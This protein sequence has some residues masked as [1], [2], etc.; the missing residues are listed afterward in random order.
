MDR[1]CGGLLP[2]SFFYSLFIVAMISFDI[3]LYAAF[4]TMLFAA[5]AALICVVLYTCSACLIIAI[6]SA[7]SG[8]LA[9]AMFVYL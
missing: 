7:V 6:S 9:S 4:T 5:V 2:P 8:V 3:S 1:L